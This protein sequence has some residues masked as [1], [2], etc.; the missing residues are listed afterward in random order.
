MKLLVGL[1]G[2]VDSAVAA[3]LLLQQ[4]H[5]VVGAFMRNWD[6]LTNNDILG[7]PT[8]DQAV[9]TQEADYQDALT[10]A[11]QLGIGLERV[12]FIQEYWDEVFTLFLR[13]YEQGRTPNP[14]I[15]CNKAIKFDAFLRYALAHGYEGIATGH[16][17]RVEHTPTTSTLHKAFD[18]SKDQSYFLAHIE[19]SALRLS[20]FPLG[21]LSKAD[22]RAIAAQLNLNV[23]HKKDSTGICFIG[24]REF[25]KFLSNYLPAKPGDM[26]DVDTRTRLGQHQGVLYYTLGQRKGLNIHAHQGPWF[27][28]GKNIH[29]NH[30][31]MVKGDHHPLLTSTACKL[32]QVHWFNPSDVKLNGAYHA[33]F[34]YRQKDQA[35]TLNER[36]D[37]LYLLYPQGIQAV[38]PGQE[39]VIYDGDCCLGGAIIDEIYRNHIPIDTLIVERLNG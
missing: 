36:P 25:R 22:V 13:E 31:Y 16:Y 28:A 39:A 19:T 11:K 3:H 9:C 17:A 32:S 10:V 15:L 23:A 29:T 27:V 33:K 20:H 5:E 12:D 35:V 30:L 2:G 24:E 8:L 14:D 4:G 26:I 21:N 37:G 18:R 38:T 34:R 6:S 1:S 7:N